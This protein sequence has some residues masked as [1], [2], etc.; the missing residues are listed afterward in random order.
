MPDASANYRGIICLL[1]ATTCLAMNDACNKYLVATMPAAEIVFLR[2]ILSGGLVLGALA[3]RGELAGVIAMRRRDIML[4]SFAESWIGPLLI[5]SLAF[6]H[7]ADATAIF[8]VAPVFVALVGFGHFKEEFSW[9]I[10]AASL[11]ALVGAWLFVNPG[12]GVIHWVAL[13]PLAASACQVLREVISRTMGKKAEG[14]TAVS[15]RVILFST[16]VFSMIAAGILALLFP[17]ATPVTDWKLPDVEEFFFLSLAAVLFYLGVIYTYDAY[18]GSDLSVVAPF[19]YWYLIVAI[20][21][22][23]FA[24]GEI[25]G[26]QSILG[27]AVIVTAGGIVLWHQHVG[28]RD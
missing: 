11:I 2:A 21:A 6:M 12:S 17:D 15:N 19:R 8:M 27:M 20:A 14:Q 7:Q 23:F 13:L 1:I 26:S 24:F 18:R 4:R 16:S 25:P 22:G 5:I 3:L 10:L 28:R 9:S